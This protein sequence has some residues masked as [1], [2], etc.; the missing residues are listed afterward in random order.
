MQNQDIDVAPTGGPAGQGAVLE[1]E[2]KIG[3]LIDK[4]LTDRIRV[5]VRTE[6]IFDR[7]NPSLHTYFESSMTEVRGTLACLLPY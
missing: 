5:P 6:T 1:I 2:A 3:R 4:S 7:N